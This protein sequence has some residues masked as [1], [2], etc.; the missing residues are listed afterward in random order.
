MIEP[1]MQRENREGVLRQARDSREQPLQYYD[2]LGF[3]ATEEQYQGILDDEASFQGAMGDAQSEVDSATTALE[4]ATGEAYAT[5]GTPQS[6]AA[7]AWEDDKT[8]WIPVNVYNG[9]NLESTYMVHR[10][11]ASR[12]QGE[13]FTGAEGSYESHF[14]DKDHN[15][16]DGDLSTAT[17]MN[18]DVTPVGV[19]NAYGAE[20]HSMLNDVTAQYRDSFMAN[21]LNNATDTYNTGISQIRSANASA[22]ERLDEAQGTLDGYQVD[23]D[24]MYG[25][26]EAR[27]NQRI[28]AMREMFS[29]VEV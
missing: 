15:V 22:Y 23:R 20:L 5:L 4:D 17:T 21:A 14:F 16:V 7:T 24:A 10:D 6:M 1:R 3:T 13:A 29:G 8:N 26:E 19:G 9:D 2:D 25:A 18:V 11:V 28:E 27:Y 12:L